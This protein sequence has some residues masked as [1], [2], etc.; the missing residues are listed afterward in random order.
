[1]RTHPESGAL[2]NEYGWGGY[3]IWKLYPARR[4][5]ID[6][7]A[8]VYGDAFMEESLQTLNGERNWRAPLE[9]YNVGTVLIKPNAPLASLLRQDAGWQSVYED[10]QAA[11]FFKR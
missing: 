6:G 9:R 7:R 5:Y 1:M 4:V 11:I 3:V 10:K 8:D 2:Y